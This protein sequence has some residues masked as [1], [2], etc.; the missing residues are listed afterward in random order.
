MQKIRLN[1]QRFAVTKTTSFEESKVSIE[2]NTSL[3]SR[4][5]CPQDLRL[6]KSILVSSVLY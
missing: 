2:D 5:D 6:C 3:L 4:N 1:I